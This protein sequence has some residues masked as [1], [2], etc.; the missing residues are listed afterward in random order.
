MT[1]Q[2]L[3]D[4]LSTYPR[5]LDLSEIKTMVSVEKVIGCNRIQ[6]V[7]IANQRI[8][9][10]HPW[11]CLQHM[12]RQTNLNAVASSLLQGLKLNKNGTKC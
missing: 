10:G 7:Y 9:G 11:G 3:M 2:E 6:C 1:I 5:H 8:A 4:Q 12:E